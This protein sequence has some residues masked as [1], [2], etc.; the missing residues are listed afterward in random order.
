MRVI[1]HCGQ[2]KTGTTTL[3]TTLARERPTLRE[4]GVCYPFGVHPPTQSHKWLVPLFLD[5]AHFSAHVAQEGSRRR[6]RP[7]LDERARTTW[8]AIKREIATQSPEV[9][10]LSSENYCQLDTP[11][12]ARRL[13]LLLS[14][15]S[16]DITICVYVRNPAD[17]YQSGVRQAVK[18]RGAFKPPG[19]L[20]IRGFLEAIE[21][22]F[23]RPPVARAYERSLLADGDIVQDF[24]GSFLAGVVG[25]ET[26]ASI[27][28]NESLS[29]EATSI[30]M[31][32]R[33]TVIP[34]SIGFTHPAAK[35]LQRILETV[36][37][38][39][40]RTGREA[41]TDD[42]RVQILRASDELD[43]L[44]SHF[45]LEF[46]GVQ[47]PVVD[48]G[49]PPDFGSYSSLESVCV[50]DEARREELQQR[51]TEH[52]MD[53][54]RTVRS[55]EGLSSKAKAARQLDAWRRIAEKARSRVTRSL[56]RST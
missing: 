16:D 9:L 54:S 10:V 56:H 2:P 55:L 5:D 3:Q 35:S 24:V 1:V 20:R 36:D 29:T 47:Y 27:S 6:T 11:E 43:W 41:L 45:G 48:G 39:V 21:E 50:V 8:S 23:G 42:L 18:S 38:T 46:P 12:E 19:P 51:V 49:P 13:R 26:L 52:L 25:L 37:P 14:D 32:Y 31:A 22:E 34:E 17:R 33:R 4:Q 40:P 15:V 30:L 7:E 53:L 44:R 28:R